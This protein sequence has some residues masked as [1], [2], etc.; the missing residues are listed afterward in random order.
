MNPSDPQS[1]AQATPGVAPSA[2]PVPIAPPTA[3]GRLSIPDRPAAWPGFVGVICTVFGCLGM[4][5]S[6]LMLIYYAAVL[7]GVLDEFLAPFNAAGPGIDTMQPLRDHRVLVI[8]SEFVKFALAAMLVFVG[9]AILHRRPSAIALATWWSVS[10]ILYTLA[11]TALGI[12]LQY[13]MLETV[14]SGQ[15]L[16][17]NAPATM[18]VFMLSGAIFGGVISIVWGC[19]LPVFLLIWFRLRHVRAETARWQPLAR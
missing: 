4:L 14:M 8:G 9:L 18:P 15:T 19:A 1:A 13:D 2:A 16:P 10:K 6:G 17:A 3:P 12:W 7:A 5:G 11:G